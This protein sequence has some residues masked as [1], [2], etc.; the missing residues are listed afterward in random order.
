MLKTYD[1][2]QLF[3]LPSLEIIRAMK[4]SLA[5]MRNGKKILLLNKKIFPFLVALTYFF[6][7]LETYMYIG[8]LSNFFLVDSRFFLVLTVTSAVML[9]IQ[10]SGFKKKNNEGQLSILLFQLNMLIFPIILI[11]YLI[12]QFSEEANYPNYIFS[13][14]HIQPENFFYVV[15][16]SFA[17]LFVDQ[18][19][20]VRNSV[21]QVTGLKG[22]FDLR[23]S[24]FRRRPLESAF[25][26]ILLGLL[27]FYLVDR[28]TY[29]LHRVINSNIYVLTHLMST[30]DDKM[31]KK[32]GF[33]YDFMKFVDEYTEDGST[34]VVPPQMGPWLT[35]GNAGLDRY[36]VYPKKIVKG[37][38]DSLPEGEYDYV[39]IAWGGWGVKDKERYGW[40]KVPVE[41]EKIWYLNTNL[42]VKEFSENYEPDDPKNEKAWGLI[43]I[44]TK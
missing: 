30:D 5:K 17:L 40:P 33:Y 21:L 25:K 24:D 31:R 23:S 34:M 6:L 14:F 35:V 37:G 2:L 28:L 29:T 3:L 16:F 19:V 38:Y 42:E 43:K 44:K 7:F 1:S 15:I 10:P 32:W 20:R 9:K 36:F 39:L 12:M 8:F 27:L 13:T 26:L 18:M 4:L 41:A 22:Q 11:F